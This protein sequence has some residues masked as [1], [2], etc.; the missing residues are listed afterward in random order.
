[1]IKKALFGL[2]LLL[3]KKAIT[4]VARKVAGKAA[5]RAAEKVLKRQPGP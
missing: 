3:G 2:A 1:M 5:K 4:Q